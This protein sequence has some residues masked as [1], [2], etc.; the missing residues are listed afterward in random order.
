VPLQAFAIAY[1]FT[2]QSA[3]IAA[4][5]VIYFDDL[6]DTVP[7]AVPLL[8]NQEF[9]FVPA[10]AVPRNRQAGM[11][12]LAEPVVTAGIFSDGT[13]AGDEA[14]IT[15]LILRRCSMLQ[16]V[17][18]SLE[19]IADAG[20][21]NVARGQMIKQFKTLANSVRRWY[22]PQEQQVGILIYQPIIGK[23]INLPEEQ[24]GSPFPPAA[25]VERETAMLNRQRTLLLESQPSLADA[26]GYTRE[27][28]NRRP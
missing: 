12:A 1:G 15:R 17:E 18:T 5:G 8:P 28:A 11:P 2:A 10:Y 14:L 23:L 13:T 16:A 24:L 9:T 7:D 25:F 27:N 6:I 4:P 22:L 21:R 26:G 20:R 19:M 3:P